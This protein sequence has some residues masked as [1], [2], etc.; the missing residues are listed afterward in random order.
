M[1]HLPQGEGIYGCGW[2]LVQ[3]PRSKRE[4]NK[5]INALKTIGYNYF[6]Y[7]KFKGCCTSSLKN[8]SID[9]VFSLEVF[10]HLPFSQNYYCITNHRYI[11]E[12][13]WLL[14]FQ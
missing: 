14:E 11:I 12:T 6:L 10:E 9:L 3:Q 13:K 1:P 7:R 5:V 4:N 8:E 2:T